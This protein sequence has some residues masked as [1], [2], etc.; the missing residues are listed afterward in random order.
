MEKKYCIANLRERKDGVNEV[1]WIIEYD[2]LRYVSCP[3]DEMQKERINP[4]YFTQ[5]DAIAFTENSVYSMMLGVMVIAVAFE[6]DE[7]GEYRVMRERK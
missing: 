5:K 2:G 3:F 7:N 6:F 4:Y 1:Y